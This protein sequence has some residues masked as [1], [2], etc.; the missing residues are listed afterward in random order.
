[1]RPRVAPRARR[2]ALSRVRAATRASSRFDRFAHAM[3]STSPTAPSSRNIACLTSATRASRAVTSRVRQPRFDSGYAS[4]RRALIVSSSACAVAR[5]TPGF[6]RPA[7]TMNRP[8]RGMPD[9]LSLIAP[10]LGVGIWEMEA[11]WHDADDEVRPP[12]HHHRLT[13]DARIA[14]EQP[15]PQPVAE[16]GDL[17]SSGSIV[18]WL[19]RASDERLRGENGKQAAA[20]ARAV[21]PLRHLTPRQIECPAGE[22]AQAV[23]A[24]GL[25][26]PVVEVGQRGAGHRAGC[27][28]RGR[29]VRPASDEDE[30]PVGLA[31]RKGPEHDRVNDAEDRG[32]RADAERQ[33]QDGDGREAGTLAQQAQP[34]AYVINNVGHGP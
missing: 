15:L 25:F 6:N 23:E 19:D 27:C 11:W 24:R 7:V 20:D 2:M 21:N 13:D 8:S 18:V 33:G 29:R 32:V 31:K 3:S 10:Q 22:E 4:A 16:D 28:R 30:E 34:E 9:I 1:M 14:A 5:L 17:G 26:A 12:F